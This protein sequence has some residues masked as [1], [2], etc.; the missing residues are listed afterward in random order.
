MVRS[1]VLITIARP[2]LCNLFRFVL[3]SF[4]REDVQHYRSGDMVTFTFSFIVI[5]IAIAASDVIL[6]PLNIG[7]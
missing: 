3:L 7:G 2:T 5:A 1:E 4:R 6:L